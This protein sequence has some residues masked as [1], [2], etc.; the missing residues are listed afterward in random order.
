M[1]AAA[2]ARAQRPRV[3]LAEFVGSTKIEQ[4]RAHIE[5][6]RAEANR[7][8]CLDGLAPIQVD[9]LSGCLIKCSA[10]VWVLCPGGSRVLFDA[11][12]AMRRKRPDIG[13]AELAELADWLRDVADALAGAGG[14]A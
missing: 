9:D 4:A 12:M 1:N 5:E 10:S 13:R 7:L 3:P 14:A 6:I 8:A 11:G 2:L